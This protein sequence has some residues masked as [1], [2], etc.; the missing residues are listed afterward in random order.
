MK[1]RDAMTRSQEIQRQANLPTRCDCRSEHNAA[2]WVLCVLFFLPE[3]LDVG[4]ALKWSWAVWA[5]R[6]SPWVRYQKLEVKFALLHRP[7]R[8]NIYTTEEKWYNNMIFF[9]VSLKTSS[10]YL[11]GDTKGKKGPIRRRAV[12]AVKTVFFKL[13]SMGSTHFVHC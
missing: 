5:N 4:E 6:P 7:F 1:A 11:L 10:Y 13:F 3:W 12:L 8:V 2:S 9:Y